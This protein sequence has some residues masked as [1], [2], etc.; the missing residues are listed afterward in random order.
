MTKHERA[1]QQG[2]NR[3]VAVTRQLNPIAE[4]LG[5]T[6]LSKLTFRELLDAVFFVQELG[7]CPSAELGEIKEESTRLTREF[8]FKAAATCLL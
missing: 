4:K 1:F 8:L 6:P 7:S 3:Q 2:I 5:N